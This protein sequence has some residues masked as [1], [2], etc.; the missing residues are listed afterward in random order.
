MSSVNCLDGGRKDALDINLY[1]FGKDN[2]QC[3]KNLFY[4][5]FDSSFLLM[6][7]YILEYLEKVTDFFELVP[8]SLVNVNFLVNFL[9]FFAKEAKISYKSQ[10]NH[11]DPHK[12][13]FL[14]TFFRN[15]E[16]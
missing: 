7:S 8:A 4:I 5:F 6:P 11:V 9:S 15:G 10:K 12:S 3:L 16:M 1:H 14:D 13:L 2:L